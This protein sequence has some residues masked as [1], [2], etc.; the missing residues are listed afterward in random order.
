MSEWQLQ[1][2]NQLGEIL[3]IIQDMN[4][5]IGKEIEYFMNSK[6]CRLEKKEVTKSN[7]WVKNLKHGLYHMLDKILDLEDK[8]I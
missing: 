7:F 3:K 4:I 8:Y 1:M 2:H 6:W 5:I